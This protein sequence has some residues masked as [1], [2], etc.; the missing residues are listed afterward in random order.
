ML[1]SLV[2]LCAPPVAADDKP[3]GW[4]ELF[5]ALGN[6]SRTVTP[7]MAAKGEK[8]ATYSQAATY[9]W[10]GGRFEVIT[11]TLARDPKFKDKYSAEAMKKE[12]AEKLEINKKT[13]YLWDRMKADDLDKV[14]RRLVVLLADDKVMEIAQRG[15][16]LELADVAK[17]LDFDKV[18]KAMDAPPVSPRP[19]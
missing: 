3:G 11:V 9:E 6:F 4:P 17:K 13:A 8:P 18:V 19:H 1:T 16:G 5:P 14:N 7:P 12:K 15:G 10:T 2:L